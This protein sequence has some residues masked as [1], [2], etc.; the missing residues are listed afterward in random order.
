MLAFRY[1]KAEAMKSVD[2][3]ISSHTAGALSVSICIRESHTTHNS[4]STNSPCRAPSADRSIPPW[5]PQ[6]C[7]A[8]DRPDNRVF[9]LSIP[10]TVFG[11]AATAIQSA[12]TSHRGFTHIIIEKPFGTRRPTHCVTTL[13]NHTVRPIHIVALTVPLPLSLI[14]LHTAALVLHCS[15]CCPNPNTSI[16]R[17]VLSAHNKQRTLRE[18]S[19]LARERHRNVQ[20]AQQ[21]HFAAV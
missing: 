21:R 17:T 4:G 13:C 3:Y 2:D 6:T 16:A 18:L 15:L 8:A 1:D 7:V 19:V 11:G 9:F 20:G 5:C 10:P 12:A 14:S